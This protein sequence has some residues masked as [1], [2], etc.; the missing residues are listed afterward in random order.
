MNHRNINKLI[1]QKSPYLLQHAHNP[2][3]WY[4]WGEEVLQRA[5]K[6]QKPLIISIGYAACHWCHVM[7]NESFE[8]NEVAEIMN[9]NFI[10]IKIDREERP[11][12]DSYYME[13]VQRIA[14]NGGW[15]LNCFALPDGR[16]FWGGTYFPK[17]NWIG[18]L[19][20]I[21]RVYANDKSSV[22]KQAEELDKAFAMPLLQD[23][24][25][26]RSINDISTSLWQVWRNKLDMKNGGE[27]AAPKFP[28]P[29]TLLALLDLHYYSREAEIQQYLL[30]TLDQMYRGGIYDQI[31]GGFSRYSTDIHWKVPHFEKMLY[32]NAQLLE[33]YSL[34]YK[35]FGMEWL[36]DA[37]LSTAHFIIN[38]LKSPNG[39]Y[40]SAIDAD[41]EGEEGAYYVWQKEDFEKIA[42]KDADLMK[43]YFGVDSEGLWENGKN[44]LLRPMKDD[45]FCESENIDPVQF[46]LRL[47]NFKNEL[48]KV[49]NQRQRPITDSKRIT[50]WNAMLLKAF[51]QT[52]SAFS[53]EEIKLEAV[54]LAHW[55]EHEP[56]CRVESIPHT[57]TQQEGFLEDYAHLADAFLSMYLVFQNESYLTFTA[58]ILKESHQSFSMQGKLFCTARSK[59]ERPVKGDLFDMVVPSANSV[60]FNSMYTFGRLTDSAALIS[61]VDEMLSSMTEKLEQ[62]P[63]AYSNWVRLALKS[64]HK[65]YIAAICGQRANSIA[66]ELSVH[67]N[68]DCLVVSTTERDSRIPHFKDKWVDDKTFIHMCSQKECLMPVESAE[69]ALQRLHKV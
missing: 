61:M 20:S 63:Y 53:L 1:D 23:P 36:R 21:I 59:N 17:N 68:P 19:K 10:C 37:A 2:V 28:M 29:S 3:D 55:L 6:E 8:D 5:M 38:E 56:A 43:K 67:Y 44:I 40:F 64:S 45:E 60:M 42:G 27:K 31:G 11:D 14:Q 50:S 58:K 34:A 57:D 16:P 35:H 22:I 62:Y 48:L 66:E 33:L 12:L 65:H 32:D 49:R 7:E 24:N 52:Y 18:L 41:S 25:S 39:G 51:A 4:P 13:A 15:P 47:I 69:E 54:A 46:N 26:D 9:S 30:N